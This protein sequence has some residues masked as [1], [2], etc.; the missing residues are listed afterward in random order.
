MDCINQF[1]HNGYKIEI[2]YDSYADSPREDCNIATIAC[3]HRRYNLGDEQISR[4]TE[5]EMR[6]NYDIADILPLYIYDHGGITIN[7]TGFSCGWDSGQVG[8]VFITN[9]A[10]KRDKLEN[11][12]LQEI[13]VNEVSGYD[14]YL[15]GDVYQFLVRDS[16]GNVVESCC[17]FYDMTDCER[18]AISIVD[19][20]SRKAS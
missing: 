1:E 4:M 19:Y 10:V 3:W 9:D 13:M 20:L 5:E 6:D 8:W 15:R 11:C 2:S 18:E 12:N 14:Q 7:T 17:G 16:D